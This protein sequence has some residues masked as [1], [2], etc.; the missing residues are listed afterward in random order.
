M[1]RYIKSTDT[2]NV[3][4]IKSLSMDD[5]M[6]E[7]KTNVSY[8]NDEDYAYIED[9]IPTIYWHNEGGYYWA[10][11]VKL[12]SGAWLEN[13][14]ISDTL[15]RITALVLYYPGMEAEI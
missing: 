10:Y 4:R 6:W 7:I 3:V 8:L 13:M 1:K 9:M 11:D 2:S 12:P 5:V 14:R 15:T